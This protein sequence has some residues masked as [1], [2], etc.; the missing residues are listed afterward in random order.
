MALWPRVRRNERRRPEVIGNRSCVMKAYRIVFPSGKTAKRLLVKAR[1]SAIADII[2]GC[3]SEQG[4]HRGCGRSRQ[5]SAAANGLPPSRAVDKASAMEQPRLGTADNAL[6]ACNL[7]RPLLFE[8]ARGWKVRAIMARGADLPWQ[9][10]GG[11]SGTV[12]CEVSD[13]D[14]RV[15]SEGPIFSLRK[16]TVS[17]AHR[18]PR[19]DPL[20]GFLATSDSLC[21]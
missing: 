16:A 4:D 14:S 6:A 17:F 13:R 15:R 8:G 12:H 19:A 1:I 11:P 2:H 18:R 9:T 20:A 7:S 21:Y 5:G 3:P 10:G